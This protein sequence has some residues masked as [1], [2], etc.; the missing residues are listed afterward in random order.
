[1][2]ALNGPASGRVYRRCLVGRPDWSSVASGAALNAAGSRRQGR[3]GACQQLVEPDR[4]VAQVSG[5][6]VREQ[7]LGELALV[8]DAVVGQFDQRRPAV[9]GV[10]QPL[11]EELRV[12]RPWLEGWCCYL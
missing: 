2:A 6:A 1:M 3:S 11:S 5:C 4:E 7:V 8:A 9:G 12:A 10:W